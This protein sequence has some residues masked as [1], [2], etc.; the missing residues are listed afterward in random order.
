MGLA[1]KRMLAQLRDEVAPK[2]EGEL[3]EITGSE[4]AYDIDWDSFAG[5]MAAMG[6]LEDKAL[7]P[8]SE[9]FRKI[10]ADKLGKEAVS[11]GV[12]SISLSHDKDAPSNVADLTLKG[13]VL[14]VRW[15]WEG[16][17]GSFFPGSVQ[18]K[19]ESML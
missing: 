8:L 2:Y 15:D 6:N 11:E 14:T 13:G 10:T 9:I 18:E 4:I 1:E 17:A 12:Q 7:K 16:W 19:I 5:S 3:R